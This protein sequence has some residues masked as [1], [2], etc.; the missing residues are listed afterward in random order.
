ML[1]R[2]KGWRARRHGPHAKYLITRMS[3]LFWHI[4]GR[5]F[6]MTYKR[7]WKNVPSARRQRNEMNEGY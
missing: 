6:F 4:E 3:R 5:T 2:W 7:P 1:P